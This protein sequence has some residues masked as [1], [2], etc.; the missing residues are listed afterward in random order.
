MAYKIHTA[1][2][3]E[4]VTIGE[5]KEQLGYLATQTLTD[6]E[7]ALINSLIKTA[8]QYVE[9]YTT[10]QIMSAT[11][12]LYLDAFSTRKIYLEK[13]PVVAVSE[14]AYKDTNGDDQI[15]SLDDIAL[16]IAYEP[17][18]L[19][20]GYGITWPTTRTIEN[21]IKITF[22]AGYASSATVPSPIKSAI[23]LIV[24]HLYEN[25]G[26]EGHRTMPK[27]I[28]YLLDPYCVIHFK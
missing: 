23:L 3:A 4:P 16:D 22:T 20:P 24:A 14:I 12:E 1:P 27:T 17:A 18:R 8:R 13:S 9:D 28:Q 5:A 19:V 10:R 11:W 21:A 7:T 25:R 26:D 6:A 2:T 15:V